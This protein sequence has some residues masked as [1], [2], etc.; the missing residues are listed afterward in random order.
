MQFKK[1]DT[2]NNIFSYNVHYTDIVLVLEDKIYLNN[3]LLL[4]EKAY[5]IGFFV[6]DYLIYGNSNKLLRHSSCVL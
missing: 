4:E 1:T 5:N 3:F 2:K 6:G